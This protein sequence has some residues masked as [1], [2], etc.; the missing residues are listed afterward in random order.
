MSQLE[1]STWLIFRNCAGLNLLIE[2]LGVFILKPGSTAL[3]VT[4]ES[5]RVS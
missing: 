5:N 1:T 4:S 3:P 2:V